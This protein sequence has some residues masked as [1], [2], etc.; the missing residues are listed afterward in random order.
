MGVVGGE[1]GVTQPSSLLERAQAAYGRRDW[2]AA[3]EAFGAAADAG[4]LGAEDR[5]ALA[6]CCWW[7]GDLVAGAR[8]LEE[9]HRVALDQGDP[10]TAAYIALELGFVTLLRGDEPVGSGW[11]GRAARL[12]EPLPEGP[13]HGYLAIAL[14]VEPG[15][16]SGAADEV[17]D[18][19]RRVQDLGRRH[20][21]PTLVAA[22]LISEGR[23]RVQAGEV[24]E[25]LALVDEA[26]VAVLADE[27]EDIIA[28]NLYCTT[29]E[30]CRELGD[31][32]RMVRW[33]EAFQGWLDTGP[34]TGMFAGDCRVHRVQLFLLHGD[35]DDAEEEATR[36]CEQLADVSTI[37]AAEAWY[38]LGELRRC[39]GDLHG[40]EEAYEIAHRLGVDPQPGLALL[41]LAQGR[42]AAAA[43]AIH[44]AL[45]AAGQDRVRRV[46][47]RAAQVEIAVAGSKL[48]VAQEA[49]EELAEF[50][51]GAVGPALV[52]QAATARGRVALAEERPDQAV[53]P[54][55]E[56][57][58]T[59]L[60]LDVP[61]QAARTG[62]L[63]ARAY[64][65]LG[66]REAA[67]R[68]LAAAAPVFA[69]LG[70][71]LDMAQIAELRGA[72]PRPGGLSDRELEVLRLVAE[73][74]SNPEIAEALVISRR[75]VA[76]HLSNIFTK[77]RVTSRTQAARFAF[78]HGLL[79]GHRP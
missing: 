12:A 60:E 31:L 50:A 21:D 11:I 16:A 53:G 29:I 22:G 27:V 4:G 70:A 76:R 79:P 59:W 33:T 46:A 73:G 42:T 19:A 69:R 41:R 47:L 13:I 23:A 6:R 78:D 36:A 61:Y 64:T 25:G 7:L 71:Q 62:V 28:G 9:A 34:S 65:A 18:A 63:L 30:I 51:A 75:T 37:N 35:W 17:L 58:R 26:M 45:L 48:D 1:G 74:R 32:R 55:R 3:R 2:A 20:G 15:L 10:G 38:E 44:A 72:E 8:H 14:E 56:A 5:F 40:A 66:D 39:R 24:T 67:D 43:T 77:L 52:A 68:E 57:A 49:C 54:L